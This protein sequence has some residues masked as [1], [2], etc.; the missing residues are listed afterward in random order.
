MGN[1]RVNRFNNGKECTDYLNKNGIKTIT[2]LTYGGKFKAKS[3][4][5][6]NIDG[7]EW[8]STLDAVRNARASGCP[9]CGNVARIICID[10]VNKWLKYNNRNIKCLHYAKRVGDS[11]S[12]FKCIIDGYE[13]NAK[14]SNIKSGKG[15]PVCS[16]V[17]RIKDINEVNKWLRDND[18]NMICIDYC[19]NVIDISIFKCNSCNKTWKSTFNNIKNGNSCPHCSASKGERHIAK[20]LDN[21]NI[22]YIAQY[23]FDDCRIKLPLPFDF[24]LFKD[25]KLIGLCEYQGEQHYKPVDFANK[26]SEWAEKQFNKNK[27]SDNTKRIYCKENNIPLLEIPYW[28]YDNAENILID[29]LKEVA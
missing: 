10:E 13:W 21:N 16:K 25:N 1:N 4:F 8:E 12:K 26:G 28:E 18:K 15:C 17:K 2:C 22:K 24:A 11:S 23:W 6:C 9:M 5:K 29:F 27:F 7:Y 14:F 19:G 20:I 3:L